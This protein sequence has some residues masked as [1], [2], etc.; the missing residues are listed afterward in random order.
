MERVTKRF[1]CNSCPYQTSIHGSIV[2]HKRTHTGDKP[3]KCDF[4]GCESKFSESSNLTNH[5][6][7]HTGE[8]PYKCDFEGCESKFSGSSSLVRHKRKHIG[9][10]PFHCNFPGC[11]S[12]F[13]Q[14]GN[15][16]NHK[17]THTGE[18]PYKCDFEGCDYKCSHSSYLVT[19]KRTHTGEKPFHCKFP[20][21]VYKCTTSTDIIRHKKVHSVEA[22]IR[23]KK[24]ELRI[25]KM[26]K[27]WGFD[28]DAEITIKSSH[29]GCVIDTDRHFSR[30]DYNIINC[31]NAILI[32][33]VDEN[34]HF[35]YEI[36]CEFS[37]MSDVR[38]SLVKSGYELPIYWI[39]Y[40]PNGKY[41]IGG[42]EVNISR[43]ERELTLKNKLEELCSPDFVPESQVN[44]HYMFYD[45]VSE[46]S[47]PE[48]MYNE[49]F[50]EALQ[51]CI[52]WSK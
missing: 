48:I 30:L 11:E 26:L 19:H 18:K 42:E 29:G 21:C 33:E 38:A 6:R 14:S 25:T 20:D 46:E 3:Y 43:E 27:K 24:Q 40:N 36:S 49:D 13:S 37:R 44:I 15:L 1:K 39:R 34:Q 8:K 32:L 52:T 28:Y 31:V 47:G 22:Q 50:P 12:K 4:E 5:K 2:K 7:T 10:K 9:T 45:L 35:W 41:S 51:D 17:R 16:V 23:Q